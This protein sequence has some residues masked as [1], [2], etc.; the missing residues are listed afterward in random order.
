M[1][2]GFGVKS[3]GQEAEARLLCHAFANYYQN[4]LSSSTH[5]LV[6]CVSWGGGAKP[7]KSHVQWKD[8]LVY[9]ED[10]VFNFCSGSETIK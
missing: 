2:V 3:P 8:G 1:T 9:W 4:S 5:F 6:T 7:C 10:L